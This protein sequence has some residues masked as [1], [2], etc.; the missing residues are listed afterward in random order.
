MRRVII[1]TN[2]F[3]RLLLDDIPEQANEIESLLKRAKK[4]E[5]EIF[6]PQIIVFEIVFALEKYY[7]LNKE[8]VLEK[9]ESLVS[10]GYVQVE[11][12]ETFVKSVD[13]YKS[14]AISFVDCFLLNIVETQNAELFTFDKKLK[15]LISFTSLQNHMYTNQPEYLFLE[16]MV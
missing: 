2:G 8:E 3:L 14:N 1:D 12:R 15:K 7:R 9:V 16:R 4:N 10:I 5:I 6:L 13:L 11:S